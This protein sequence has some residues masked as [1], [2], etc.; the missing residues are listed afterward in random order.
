MSASPGG[1]STS[2]PSPHNAAV[3]SDLSCSSSTR[4]SAFPSLKVEPSTT[5]SPSHGKSGSCVLVVVD[6]VVVVVVVVVGSVV[7]VVVVGSVVVVA[8]VVVVG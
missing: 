8:V 3:A 1:T 6:S 7:V 4:S 2:P 5:R